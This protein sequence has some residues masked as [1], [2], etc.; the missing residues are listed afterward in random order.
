MIKLSKDSMEFMCRP[1]ANN[2]VGDYFM[3]SDG[4]KIAALFKSN[5]PDSFKSRMQFLAEDL[6]RIFKAEAANDYLYC[7][8]NLP[9]GT[10]THEGR[11]GIIL[12]SYPEEFYF[13]GGIAKNKV[14]EG[15]WFCSEKLRNKYLDSANRGNWYSFIV[16]IKQMAAVLSLLEEKDL[17]LYDLSYRSILFNPE[18]GNI[19]II[20]W[21]SIGRKGIDQVD[22]APTP[23]FVAPEI[24][25]NRGLLA[26]N[27][28]VYANRHALAVLNY[29]LLFHRHPL[30]GKRINDCDAARDEELTMGANALFI[31]HTSDKS[32]S[33]DAKKLLD[34][35]K[36]YGNPELRPYTLSGKIL[37]D[38]FDRSFIDGLHNPVKRPTPFEWFIAAEKTL[39]L[40]MPCSNPECEEKWFIYNNERNP[41]CPFCGAEIRA[42]Y[43]ILNFYTRHN[44]GNFVS[45]ELR[46][47][48][49]ERKHLHYRHIC[50][51]TSQ[52]I[53]QHDLDKQTYCDFKNE[54]GKWYLINNRLRNLIV[55]E[56]T[57]R[58]NIPLEDVVELKD[59]MKL[60]F[61]CVSKDRLIIVQ[62]LKPK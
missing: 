58:T 29:M 8:C 21:D 41:K 37:K 60:V 50:N 43:P 10:I 15:K 57:E 59:G 56:G 26:N 18:K 54:N 6:R 33:V 61:D 51:Q 34:S 45:D 48:V 36:P 23:D 49:T 53:I 27:Q 32:N 35:E 31:E 14:Q 3:L 44:T 42:S 30:R 39:G 55:I 4:K 24:I 20:L 52:S 1:L 5:V 19:Y 40:L 22:I 9:L 46:M 11:Y 38:L 13:K 62:M 12:S 47:V 2:S 16:A 7:R 28:T 25:I 17:I